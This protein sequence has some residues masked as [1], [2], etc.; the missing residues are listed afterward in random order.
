VNSLSFLDIQELPFVV[1]DFE[2]EFLSFINPLFNQLCRFYEKLEAQQLIEQL[3]KQI[4][5]LYVKRR[6]FSG[7]ATSSN[8]L[9]CENE[10][11]KIIYIA[12][13]DNKTVEFDEDEMQIFQHC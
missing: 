5:V 8:N 9:A 7:G 1:P 13:K 10:A 6:D 4:T 3:W 11:K 2:K 12:L